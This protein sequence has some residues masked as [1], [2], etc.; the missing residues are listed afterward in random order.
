MRRKTGPADI[1]YCSTFC[2]NSNCKRNLLFYKAPSKYYSCSKF[3]TD[4]KDELHLKCKY[5]L[6]DKNDER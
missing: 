5:K 4:D 1:S 2:V 3:D 6:E